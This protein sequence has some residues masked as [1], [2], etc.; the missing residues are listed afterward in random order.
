[1][2]HRDTSA[3]RFPEPGTVAA[4]LLCVLPV[5]ASIAA[6]DPALPKA[7]S[8]WSEVLTVTKPHGEV[9]VLKGAFDEVVAAGMNSRAAARLL[10]HVGAYIDS[11]VTERGSAIVSLGMIVDAVEA[12]QARSWSEEDA[13]RLVIALQRDL[14]E[15]HVDEAK[16]LQALIG[17][18]N[19]GTRADQ[20]LGDGETL[21]EAPAH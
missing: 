2:R 19:R 10:K 18:V 13:T 15:R 6:A 9:E 20:I 12:A 21:K 7:K 5:L 11:E 4:A 16:R 14:N 8:G 1:M 17:Q 3:V